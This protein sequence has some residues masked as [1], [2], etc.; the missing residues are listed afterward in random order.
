MSRRHTGVLDD[1]RDWIHG[2]SHIKYALVR[3]GRKDEAQAFLQAGLKK[4]PNSPDA[5]VF[6][7]QFQVLHLNRPDKGLASFR[8]ALDLDK[9]HAMAIRN[10]GWG[11]MEAGQSDEAIAILEQAAERK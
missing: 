1:H 11:L 6:M 5:H 4:F 3:L 9:K 2:W 8:K 10:L 7:G